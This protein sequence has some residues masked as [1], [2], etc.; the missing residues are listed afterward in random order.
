[1]LPPTPPPSAA[2]QIALPSLDMAVDWRFV[3]ILFCSYLSICRLDTRL[4]LTIHLQAGAKYPSA[5]WMLVCILSGCL[6]GWCLYAVGY[7]IATLP[8]PLAP[9]L[10]WVDPRSRCL[11]AV[12][13]CELVCLFVCLLPSPPGAASEIS[14]SQIALP[15]LLRLLAE[16]CSIWSSLLQLIVRMQLSIHLHTGWPSAA[17]YPHAGCPSAA[18]YPS[19]AIYPHAGC[20]SAADYPSAAIYPHAGCLSDR[21]AALICR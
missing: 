21:R 17:I 19:A 15:S 2:P 12:P 11:S 20:P 3:W 1:M 7:A 18:D 8:P 9:H 13:C 4:Q 5:G 10:R 14:K 6:L 16:F